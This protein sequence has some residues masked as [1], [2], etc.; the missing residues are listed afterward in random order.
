MHRCDTAWFEA[1]GGPLCCLT[2]VMTRIDSPVDRGRHTRRAQTAEQ[3]AR[4]GEIHGV[5]W[6]WWRGVE[7][8]PVDSPSPTER[9]VTVT[10]ILPRLEEGREGDEERRRPGEPD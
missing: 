8:V 6:W 1:G 5:R 9:E 2:A 7:G 10:L 4:R 3:K